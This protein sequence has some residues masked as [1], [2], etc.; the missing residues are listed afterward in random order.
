MHKSGLPC[1]MKCFSSLSLSVASHIYNTSLLS[2]ASLH[3]QS[4]FKYNT[5]IL[6]YT[7]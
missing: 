5:K 6:V 4:Q 2:S 1:L 3:K 7:S